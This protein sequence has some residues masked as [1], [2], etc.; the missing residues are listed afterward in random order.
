MPTVASFAATDAAGDGETPTAGPSSLQPCTANDHAQQQQPDNPHSPR[1]RPQLHI[2]A[3][4]ALILSPANT[5]GTGQHLS[6][7]T[8]SGPDNTPVADDDPD[9]V[10]SPP[11]TR[12]RTPA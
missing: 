10:E 11:P 9:L 5:P 2:A 7:T 1:P 8:T 6:S 12:H 3:H 4:S